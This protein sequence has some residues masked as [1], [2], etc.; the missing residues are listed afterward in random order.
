[1]L[2]FYWLLISRQSLSS[3]TTMLLHFFC[4]LRATQQEHPARWRD[5]ELLTYWLPIYACGTRQHRT[6][7]IG[8]YAPFYLA[9]F[10]CVCVCLCDCV[11]PY[12][13]WF[14][15][16]FLSFLRLLVA[17]VPI[18]HFD[19]CMKIYDMPV[20]ILPDGSVLFSCKS[21]WSNLYSKFVRHVSLWSWTWGPA[22]F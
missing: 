22:T 16:V 12:V 7:L 15:P 2:L 21:N 5:S 8:F 14:I 17:E 1:M 9:Y 18:K 4:I 19:V 20:Y 6:H 10:V 3:L 13:R 11:H